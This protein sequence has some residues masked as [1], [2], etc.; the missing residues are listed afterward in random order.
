MILQRS[1]PFLE[2]KLPAGSLPSVLKCCQMLAASVAKHSRAGKAVRRRQR[3]PA[4]S[5]AEK[6][7]TVQPAA[8]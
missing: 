5:E 2:V 1:S 6:E 7:A 3:F 4:T 8:R